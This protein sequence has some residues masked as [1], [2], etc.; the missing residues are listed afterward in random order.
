MNAPSRIEITGGTKLVVTW[1][2]GIPTSIRAADLRAACQCADCR[3]DAG[4]ARKGSVLGRADEI[5][6]S[7]AHIVGAYAVGLEFAPDGHSTGIFSY[8]LLAR[9]SSSD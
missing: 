5:R 1:E 7:G 6:I 3:S 2:D 9:I 4:I 8:E